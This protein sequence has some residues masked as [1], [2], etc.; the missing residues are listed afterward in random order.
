MYNIYL[1]TQSFINQWWP[2]FNFINDFFIVEFF[3][4]IMYVYIYNY[5]NVYYT[6]LYIFINFFLL[7]IYLA[8][9]QIELFTAFLWLVECS[10]LFIFLL[11]LFYVNVKG[12]HQY[13]YTYQYI[14]VYIFYFFLYFILINTCFSLNLDFELNYFYI[15]DNF[16]ESLYNNVNND[17]IG[18]FISYFLINSV[19]FLVIGFLLLV[20]SVLC[21]YLFQINKTTRTQPYNNYLTVFNFFLDFTNF[22]FLRKQNLIKQGNTKSSLKLF[23]KK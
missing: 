22:F 20:G 16:Y 9:F 4:I 8:M 17:L 6:L 14:Y 21:V 7:G 12:I 19:E 10:V 5:N 2:W 3:I 11:L 15:L 18:F 13:L 23:K 1:N